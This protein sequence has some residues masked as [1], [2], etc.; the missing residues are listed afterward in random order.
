[1]GSRAEAGLSP[2]PHRTPHGWQ[3]DGL[4]DTPAGLRICEVRER[5]DPPQEPG[6]QGALMPSLTLQLE[7]PSSSLPLKR[8]Y[9]LG[10]ALSPG[11][12]PSQQPRPPRASS[13]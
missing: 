10:V 13:P 2:G 5:M 7:S 1:M 4:G 11:E 12:E 8:N 3:G 9:L 6:H